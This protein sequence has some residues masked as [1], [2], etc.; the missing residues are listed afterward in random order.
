[1]VRGGTWTLRRATVGA[2]ADA[3]VVNTSGQGFNIKNTILLDGG[4]DF[5]ISH[6]SGSGG[7]FR[8]ESISNINGTANLV[9]QGGGRLDFGSGYD[10]AI[11][12]DITFRESG[13]VVRFNKDFSTAASLIVDPLSEGARMNIQGADN[14][15][16]VAVL[17]VEGY[18]FPPGSYSGPDFNTVSSGGQVPDVVGDLRGNF[19]G[20]Y[21][22]STDTIVVTG[23]V[24]PGPAPDAPVIWGIELS[25][26][27]AVLRWEGTNVA[28]YS[29]Q[30]AAEP[31][32]GAWSNTVGWEAMPGV[33]GTMSAILPMGHYDQALPRVDRCVV[34]ASARPC[35]R[36]GS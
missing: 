24:G 7:E 4:G 16:T 31:V 19:E 17:D 1:M 30:E 32:T 25:G 10:I 3:A 21:S 15:F 14:T 33:D 26:T 22:A 23:P 9:F 12:G 20:G 18:S 35:C 28:T 11:D 13:T 8:N 36:R 6:N 2:L 29:V 27:D 34:T 5:V